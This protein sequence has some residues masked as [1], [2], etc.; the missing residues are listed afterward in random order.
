MVEQIDVHDR[1]PRQQVLDAL[2]VVLARPAP[3]AED[4]VALLESVANSAVDE[5]RP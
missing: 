5:G 1:D 3:H 4:G 2:A